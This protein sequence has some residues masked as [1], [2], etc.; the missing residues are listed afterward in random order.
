MFAETITYPAALLAGLLSFFS[1]CILPLIPAYFSF[2]TGLSLDELTEDKKETRQKVILSTLAYVLGFSFIFILFGAS[3]SF[4]GGLAAKYSWAV[5]YLG[6]GIIIVFGLHLLGIINIK[7][8]NFEKKIHMKEKPVHLLGTFVIG[9]AFG[10]G[11]SP[12]IGPMLGS[13]LIVAGN[14]ETIFEGIALLAVY[15]AGLAFPFMLIS[16]FITHLLEIM[17]KAKKTLAIINKVAG[18]LLI[19]I[20][21]LLI[22]DKFKLLIIV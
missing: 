16:F 15:S 3:A 9:M 19:L 17:R 2:I 8:L 14:Q 20:G 21:I 4:L 5:R 22:F 12:C 11:W 1:P 10:A 13:I 18:I 6:G 7:A